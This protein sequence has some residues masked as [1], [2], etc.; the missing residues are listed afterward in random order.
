MTRCAKRL[1]TALMLS[2]LLGV[3]NAGAQDESLKVVEVRILPQAEVSGKRFTL[4]EVA[5]LD[6]F[7]LDAVRRLAKVTLGYSPRPGGKMRLYV[8]Q[9][10]SRLYRVM[11]PERIRLVMPKTVWVARAGQ[12]VTAKE[13]ARMVKDHAAALSDRR[14]DGLLQTISG[15]VRDAVLPVGEVK[16]KITPIGRHLSAGGSRSFRVA[17]KVN[18]EEVWRT[19]VRVKQEV[20][21]NIA[22]AVKEIRRGQT[23]RP[24]DIHLKSQ[25]ISGKNPDRYITRLRDVIG[26]KAKRTIGRG[27]RVQPNMVLTPAEVREGG[28]VT[29]EYR[30]P[31]LHLRM[32]GVALVAGNIG[33]FIPVRNLQSGRI[34]YG[35][36]KNATTV[37]VN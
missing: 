30:T 22:V 20:T 27:E 17:A 10:R 23:I 34:I 12:V 21:Q 33:D 36:I 11:R 15:V 14:D 16:W 6:G 31:L 9:V 28:R 13:I 29:I 24:E 19:L 4:G 3:S 2:V 26:K 18:G 37:K 25:N 1:L 32:P 8:S 35:V 5:E 7:D